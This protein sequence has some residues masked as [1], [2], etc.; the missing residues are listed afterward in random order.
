MRV[1]ELGSTG[2][3]GTPLGLGTAALGRPGYLNLGHG[4]DLGADRSVAAMERHAHAML[5]AAYAAGIRHVDAA[6][7]YGHAE[8]FVASWLDARGLASGDLLVSSKWGYTYTGGWRADA[9]VH[10]VKDHSLPALRRQAAESRVILGDRLKLYQIHSAT[11]DTGVLQDRAIL[12][13]LSRLAG[14]GMVIGL[15]VS[16]PRQGDTIRRAL[17]VEVDGERLF[18]SVQATWNLL[19]PSAGPALA[20]AHDAG[21]AV[22][23]K[24]AVANGRLTAQDEEGPSLATVRTLLRQSAAGHGVGVDALAIAA[25]LA[26]PW[27]D[28]VLSGAVITPHLAGNLAA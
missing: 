3:V 10:E 9:Q 1:R 15:S 28:V 5:D 20:E 18:R 2:L 14:D 21:W 26:Q 23:I 4:R 22:I 8:E 13:E 12:T 16:G 19:E 27:A 6:R 25:A 17:E 11:L 24:E 7:S